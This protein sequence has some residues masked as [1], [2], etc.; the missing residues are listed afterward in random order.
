MLT[1]EVQLIER[2][3]DSQSKK[4]SDH[5]TAKFAYQRGYLIGLLARLAHNDSAVK[6]QILQRL[7][8]P[9]H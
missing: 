7:S 3:L 9:T 2:L 6:K 8:H 1:H 4:Y 5:S